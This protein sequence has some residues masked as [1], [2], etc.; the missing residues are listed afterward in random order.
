LANSIQPTN[1]LILG[2]RTSIIRVGAMTFFYVLFQAVIVL[3]RPFLQVDFIISFYISALFLFGSYFFYYVSGQKNHF[4]LHVI[5]LANLFYLFKTQPQ[6]SSFY[7]IMILIVLF[8][9]CLELSERHGLYL[10]V[11][12][13]L[14]ISLLNLIYFRWLGL[15][16]VLNL[17]L[18]NVSFVS[19]FL[20]SSQLRFELINLNRELGTTVRKLR[21]KEELSS[22]LI[23]KMPLGVWACD[24]QGG[25]L[26][27]NSFLSQQLHLDGALM[28][29]ILIQRTKTALGDWCFYHPEIRDKRY[30]EITESSYFDAEQSNA[31]SLYLL[32]DVTDVRRLQDEMRQKEKLAAV[33]QLAAGIA[34]EIRNPLAG[35][36]GSIELL[37][38][39]RSNPDD[40]KLMKIILKEI[41]RLNR[42]ITDFLDYSKPEK[43]P[44][45]TVDLALI[46]EECLQNVKISSTLQSPLSL[47]TDLQSQLIR[48]H[49][50]KL[51]QAVLN[52]LVNAVQAMRTVQ[53]PE[54]RV[55][56]QLQGED[57]VLSIKDNGEGM[58]EEVQKRIFEP[59]FT[60]KSKG[61][62][63]GMAM[64][65]K[66]LESHAA[67]IDL[68]SVVGQGTEFKLK[69]RKV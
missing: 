16:N 11:L 19:V 33:G 57:V 34:H 23:E 69:F 60:T 25:G 49:S 2:S 9:S 4:V 18:F 51:R 43:S 66:I 7:L 30:Y 31:V 39:E 13:S 29:Q 20:F 61:T 35:I 6:F 8:L 48:G 55:T 24:A 5:E 32:K 50:D 54:L 47:H 63:L 22:L 58:S 17:A 21:S 65:H 67:R 56:L 68:L 36:S 12:A 59:F 1:E 42:L 38:Q 15:Q 46:V 3:Q 10:V 28:S 40:Q 26:F 53:N 41:D 62:G 27:S 52:I 45:Q 37:S 14:G 44:D 64:T